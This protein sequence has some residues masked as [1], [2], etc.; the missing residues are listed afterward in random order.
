MKRLLGPDGCPW[1]HE[2]TL[3]T[4]KPFLIEECYE[5]IDAID[6]GEPRA[7]CEELGDVLLQIVFQS[8][9]AGFEM[10]AVIQGIGDKLIRRHPHVFGDVEV[11]DA[12]EVLVN[13]EAI[14][15]KEKA[16]TRKST[17]DGVPRGLPALHRSHELTRKAAKAG[18]RW[19]DSEKAREKVGEELAEVDEALSTGDTEAARREVGDLLFS[20]AAWAREM[21]I[22]PEDALRL[23]NER[24]DK[25]FRYLEAK[26]LKAG[27][28]MRECEESELLLRW[29]EAK[30][31]TKD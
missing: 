19:R 11:A 29:L 3:E 8:E 1:D 23:A 26:V 22:Q 17:L 24:F 5:L 7:H 13:W 2:Q 21:G 4:L 9:L 6:S 30:A 31:A 10:G 16:A 18:F 20:V 15:A 12:D 28:D 25:R 14:K 27:G